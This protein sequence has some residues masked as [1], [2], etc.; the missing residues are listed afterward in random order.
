[1]DGNC[2]DLMDPNGSNDTVT[3]FILKEGV[4]VL[5]DK[6]WTGKAHDKTKDV[7]ECGENQFFKKFYLK[8]KKVETLAR[9][10]D[11]AMVNNLV[12]VWVLPYDN[13]GTMCTDIF[14]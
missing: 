9:G 2:C 11:G 13:L 8:S 5:Y 6:V 12:G 7:D 10:K 4:N 1:M 14:G 3:G